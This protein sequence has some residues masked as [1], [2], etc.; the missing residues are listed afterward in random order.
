MTVRDLQ[1]KYLVATVNVRESSTMGHVGCDIH[2]PT[3]TD[4]VVG[5]V[6]LVGLHCDTELL[7][8][9]CY[10]QLELYMF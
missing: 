3:L 10:N 7:L 1:P 8:Q 5:V 9:P 4:K 6:G 2:L